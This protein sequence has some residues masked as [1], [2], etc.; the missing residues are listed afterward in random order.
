MDSQR[1]RPGRGLRSVISRGLRRN[2]DAGGINSVSP[3]ALRARIEVLEQRLLLAVT[4]VINEF[5]ASNH[6]T[7]NDEDGASSD[8]IEIYNPSDQSLNLDGYFLTDD[9]A[10][11]DKWRMPAATVSPGGYL[12]VFASGKDRAVAGQELHTNFQLAADGGYVGLV[13]TDHTT[14]LSSYNYPQQLTD[15]SYGLSVDTQVTHLVNT[16]AAVKVFVP[17]NSSLGTTWT[18]QAFNDSTWTT[19]TTGVGYDL[20]IPP[21]PISGFTIK[22]VDFNEQIGDIPTATRILSGDTSGYTV[23]FTGKKD[24]ATVNQGVGG[25]FSPDDLDPE[26]LSN[27]DTYALRATANVFIPAGTWSF[28]VGSDDGMSLTIPGATFTTGSGERTANGNT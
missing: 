24:Y 15:V 19:G 8:W 21:P 10:V 12:L 3:G 2:R 11:L 6:N 26:G 28:D 14:V 1:R 4:P 9:A 17:T 18:T 7:I 13:A 25:N 16:G 5:M 27:T 20:N 23:S 22:M